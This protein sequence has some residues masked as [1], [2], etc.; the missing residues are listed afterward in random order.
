MEP[1]GLLGVDEKRP[2]GVTLTPC[3]RGKPLAWDV[4]VTNVTSHIQTTSTSA[5]EAVEKS[6]IN[7]QVQQ[8]PAAHL[9]IP[10]SSRS[11]VHTNLLPL[12]CSYQSPAAHLFIPIAIDTSGIWCSKSSQFIKELGNRITAITNETLETTYL[13]QR[14][15]MTY[16]EAMQSPSS[17][18]QILPTAV[19]LFRYA[20]SN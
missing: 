7:N 16:R 19:H 8:S 17:S 13:F 14:L 20:L 2:D 11:L 10:I 3:S 12:T 4:T 6:A 15:S 5:G 18:H 9:F 1:F